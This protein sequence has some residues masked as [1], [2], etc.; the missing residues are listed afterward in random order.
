MVSQIVVYLSLLFQV[1]AMG[2]AIS[3]FKRT[4]FNAAWI[5]ISTGFFL[6]TIYRVIELFPSMRRGEYE[7]LYLTKVWLSFIISLAFAIGVFYIRKVFQFLRRLDEIRDESEKRVV[8]AIIRTEEQERQRFAKE[9]HDGLG[10]LLSVIKMLL[11]GFNTQNKEEVNERIKNNLKQAVDE[12]I[13]S[14]REI[15]A[16]ISPHILNNFGLKDATDSFI[17][18][19]RPAEGIDIQFKTNIA[20]RR[21]TYNVE[22]IMYRVICELINNTL[23]HAEATKVRIDLRYRNDMLYLEY[24]DNGLGFDMQQIENEGGMGLSNMRYRLNSGNGD[25]EIFSCQGKGMKAT[26]FIKCNV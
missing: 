13:V 17:R 2:F 9:L 3:L 25:I 19:L 26:A 8:S 1:V 20:G 24:E 4:K 22:V 6:M 21:F 12:A 23:R 18:K 11:S 14:V 5:L 16:N 15:S 10:P 7:E